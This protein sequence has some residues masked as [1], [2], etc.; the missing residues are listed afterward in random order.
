MLSQR[1][2]DERVDTNG[3]HTLA[4]SSAGG[5]TGRTA[6]PA[7]AVECDHLWASLLREMAVAE[8]CE[9]VRAETTT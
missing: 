3:E 9:W 6:K 4:E 2:L 5:Q 8:T 7:W 1:L